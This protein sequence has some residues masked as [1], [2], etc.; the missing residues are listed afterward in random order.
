VTDQPPPPPDRVGTIAGLANIVKGLSLSH[1]MTIA[2][3]VVIAAP[4]FVLYRFMT[5]SSLL[6][7]WASFYEELASDKVACTL[8]IAS[9]RGA[10]P[11]YSISTGFAFQGSDRYTVAVLLTHKP[12]DGQLMSYCETLNLIVDYMRRPD[13]KSPTFPNSDE[14]LIWHYRRDASP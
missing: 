14:E 11:V 13:A 12:D 6:N 2:L 7:K 8:R 4:T 10:D 5:D 9:Q 3:L 1:V